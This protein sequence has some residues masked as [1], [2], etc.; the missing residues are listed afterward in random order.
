VGQLRPCS[1]GGEHVC[2]RG[3]LVAAMD[4]ARVPKEDNTQAG[5]K[6]ACACGVVEEL[7]WDIVT[8]PQAGPRP[9]N[10]ATRRDV[11]GGRG[12]E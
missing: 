10:S 11:R 7:S 6:S 8:S 2:Q 1:Q 9:G 5:E 4:N 3:E 12:S